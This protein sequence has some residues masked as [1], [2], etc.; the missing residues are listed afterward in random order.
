MSK[1]YTSYIHFVAVVSIGIILVAG[2]LAWI[3]NTA[4]NAPTLT[5]SAAEARDKSTKPAIPGLVISLCNSQPGDRQ[6]YKIASFQNPQFGPG[7]PSPVNKDGAPMISARQ[8]HTQ[9]KSLWYLDVPAV[10]NGRR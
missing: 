6:A 1:K 3:F 8:V 5:A 10:C 9:S 4:P 2:I 7:T